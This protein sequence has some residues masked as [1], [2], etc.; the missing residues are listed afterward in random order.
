VRRRAH[1]PIDAKKNS[2]QN[3]TPSASWALKRCSHHPRWP[4]E[5]NQ[6]ASVANHTARSSSHN[7]KP[8]NSVTRRNRN[9][10]TRDATRNKKPRARGTLSFYAARAR[11]TILAKT[12]SYG[13][14]A[15]NRLRIGASF[16][17]IRPMRP[18][19]L[20]LVWH[21]TE[22]RTHD[23]PALVEA[24]KRAQSDGGLVVPIVIIDPKIFGRPDLT[25]RRQ[26]HFLE[27]VRALRDAYRELGAD[28]WCAKGIRPKFWRC[29]RRLAS[30]L[31]RAFIRNYTP[32]AKERDANRRKP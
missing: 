32:Y 26:A 4:T 25:P 10:A 19:P 15:I 2:S 5:S 16:A 27:N 8:K 3:E 20:H 24:A 17:A 31:K 28:W 23:N 14:K 13:C 7:T 18:I 22:L 11:Q 6:A 21:R 1:R 29:V 12:N 9:R 30:V